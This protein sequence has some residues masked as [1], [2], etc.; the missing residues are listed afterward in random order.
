[1][2]K[3]TIL[4]CETTAEFDHCIEK[5]NRKSSV[6]SPTFEEPNTPEV[7]AETYQKLMTEKGYRVSTHRAKISHC[8]R[9]NI[10]V[11]KRGKRWKFN[12]EDINKV[13]L[14][15]KFRKKTVTHFVTQNIETE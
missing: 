14:H 12:L 6:Q 13:P 7:D 15:R 5:I 11:T 1:M 8:K 9:F 10:S 4:E 3:L 2:I